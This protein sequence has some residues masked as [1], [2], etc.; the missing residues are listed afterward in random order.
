MMNSFSES[1]ILAINLKTR[2]LHRY[3]SCTQPRLHKSRGYSHTTNEQP[4]SSNRA[5][6]DLSASTSHHLKQPQ[7]FYDSATISTYR[8]TDIWTLIP[9]K[10]SE[11]HPQPTMAT[12]RNN[13]SSPPNRTCHKPQTTQVHPPRLHQPAQPLTSPSAQPASSTSS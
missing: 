9:T 1:A 7:P 3:H 4:A 8:L 13:N 12:F 10:P 11:Q 2:C 6:R 5:N